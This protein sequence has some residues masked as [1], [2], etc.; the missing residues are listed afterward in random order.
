M[1]RFQYINENIINIK[2]DI[3]AG[4]L[5]SSLL[6]YYAIYSRLDYYKKLS[7]SI[8]KAVFLTSED[9]KVSERTIFRI[10][11]NMEEEI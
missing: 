9:F 11:K 4:I 3:R 10:I 1:I 5:P 6:R 7:N 8:T 2:K